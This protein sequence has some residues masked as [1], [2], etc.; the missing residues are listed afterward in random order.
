MKRPERWEGGFGLWVLGITLKRILCAGL[1]ASL[2][3]PAF[4]PGVQ[5]KS[6]RCDSIGLD[7]EYPDGWVEMNMGKLIDYLKDNGLNESYANGIVGNISLI[8]ESILGDVGIEVDLL[9]MVIFM[10]DGEDLDE[11]KGV[12]LFLYEYLYGD[13]ARKREIDLEKSSALIF[14][15]RGCVVL[16]GLQVDNGA[17]EKILKSMILEGEE[18]EDEIFPIWIWMII[19]ILAVGAAVIPLILI[20]ATRIRDRGVEGE[21]GGVEGE[22]GGVEGERGDR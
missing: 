16:I 21:A 17:F 10:E 19:G 3:L 9:D 20:A 2:I 14:G 12:L 18:D 4:I 15:S 7:M 1:V 13:Y 11:S 6:Y 8:A 5:G 22:A